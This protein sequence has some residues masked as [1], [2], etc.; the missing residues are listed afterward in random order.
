MPLCWVNIEV[1]EPTIFDVVILWLRDCFCDAPGLC[2]NGAWSPEATNIALWVTEKKF[3]VARPRTL[4][5]D[6]VFS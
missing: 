5:S 2:S 1:L 6:A 3:P 4:A